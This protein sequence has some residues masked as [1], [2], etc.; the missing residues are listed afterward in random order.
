[1]LST[2]I[3]KYLRQKR[4]YINTTF[5][6]IGIIETVKKNPM[7]KSVFDMIFSFLIKIKCQK[8]L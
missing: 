4:G 6:N 1:M 7:K 5:A 2:I 8:K 3:K